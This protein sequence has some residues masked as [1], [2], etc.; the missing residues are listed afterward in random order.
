M[1]IHDG[2]RRVGVVVEL[3]PAPLGYYFRVTRKGGVLFSEGFALVS[4]YHTERSDAA[5][6]LVR[7]R[8]EVRGRLIAERMNLLYYI[9][10]VAAE[11]RDGQTVYPCNPAQGCPLATLAREIHEQWYASMCMDWVNAPPLP[12]DDEEDEDAPLSDF[13]TEGGTP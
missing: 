13:I 5:D 9:P 1:F 7:L 4:A 2:E 3:T 8:H 11:R 10:C 6:V 12:D